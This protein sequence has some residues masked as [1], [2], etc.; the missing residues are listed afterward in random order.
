MNPNEKPLPL[1]PRQITREHYAL[2]ADGELVEIEDIKQRWVSARNDHGVFAGLR[3]TI[4]ASKLY[5][6][7]ITPELLTRLGFVLDRNGMW[8]HG[9]VESVSLSPNV[10][11]PGFWVGVYRTGSDMDGEYVCTCYHLMPLIQLI[12]GLT[13]VWLRLDKQAK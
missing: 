11:R 8:Y 6:V 5:P 1:A 9:V 12:E 2:T 13:G 10:G 4:S 7:P 3:V